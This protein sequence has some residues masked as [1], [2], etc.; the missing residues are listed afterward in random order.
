MDLYGS[1]MDT[2]NRQYWLIEL[3]AWWEGEV[4]TRHLCEFFQISR[5]QASKYLKSYQE[6]HPGHLR[7]SQSHKRYV[8]DQGFA[9]TRI[10][11]DVNEYLNW[12]TG[13]RSLPPSNSPLLSLPH[14][15]ITQPPRRVSNSV[16]R[17]LVKALRQQRRLEVDYQSVS[18]ADPDGRI[19]VPHTFVN[20][21]T[22]WHLRAWC[23]K[24]RDYRDFVLSRF[25]GTP[26]LLGPSEQGPEQ[27]RA[28][29]TRVNIILRPDPRLSPTQ[30]AILEQDYGMENGQLTLD[31]PVPLWC[32]TCFRRCRSV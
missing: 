18:S 15:A 1:N 22:R 30:Q 16:M 5:Q 28:W 7:Y 27:D 32:S 19:I 20:A 3:L 9:P 26:E 13:T 21:G 6:R 14:C 23:E 2:S 8:P 11:R 12:L 25:R 29:N 10:S 17:E 4:C 24:N 31:H